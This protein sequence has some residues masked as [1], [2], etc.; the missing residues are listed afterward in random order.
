[1]IVLLTTPFSSAEEKI[2]SNEFDSNCLAIALSTFQVSLESQA[3]L[4]SCYA[5][6]V[7]LSSFFPLSVI[8]FPESAQ[9]TIKKRT[10]KD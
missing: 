6:W 4:I 3:L 8:Q 5:N 7:N 9:A 1:M 10:S 2:Q